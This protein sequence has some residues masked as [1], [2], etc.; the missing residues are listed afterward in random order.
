MDELSYIGNADPSAID[1]LYKEY[2]KNPDNVDLGWK[3]FSKDS[4]LPISI[5]K[6]QVISQKIIKRI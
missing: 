2:Q 1:Y 6:T 3:K 5:M 4:N